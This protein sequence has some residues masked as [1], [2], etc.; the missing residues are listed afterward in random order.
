MRSLKICGR[1][2]NFRKYMYNY[3]LKSMALNR[4]FMSEINAY[5]RILLFKTKNR[6]T[7][8]VHSNSKSA[9]PSIAFVVCYLC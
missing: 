8:Y 2:V 1:I 5:E 9:V 3:N 6:K 7:I 4:K